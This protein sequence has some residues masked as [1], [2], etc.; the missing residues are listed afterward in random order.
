[1]RGGSHGDWNRFLWSRILVAEW[2]TMLLAQ[3]D[4]MQ[5]M[6]PGG[7]AVVGGGEPWDCVGSGCARRDRGPRSP[8]Q[9]DER[10]PL[11]GTFTDERVLV[12]GGAWAGVRGGR[13]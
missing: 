4:L 5:G 12:A 2:D 10:A 11:P 6:L 8:R 9:S 7:V 13:Y 1:M 3:A